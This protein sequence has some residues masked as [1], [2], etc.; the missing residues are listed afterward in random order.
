MKKDVPPAVAIAIVVVIVAVAGLLFLR[1]GKRAAP[2]GPAAS[3]SG[4]GMPPQVSAE[5]QKRMGGV[6]PPRPQ[7]Q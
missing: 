3:G 7:G 2:V 1:A 4:G 6:Q 5:L